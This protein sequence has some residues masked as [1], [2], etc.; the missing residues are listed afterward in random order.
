MG[1]GA[2][3]ERIGT[4]DCWGSHELEKTKQ[5]ER[6][7]VTCRAVFLRMGWLVCVIVVKD[8]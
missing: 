3:E 6:P 4:R 1:I 5:I 7:I 8:V 2:F